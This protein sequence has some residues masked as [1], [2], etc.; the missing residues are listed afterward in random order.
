MSNPDRAFP[1]LS[2]QQK[3]K[4]SHLQR[5]AY[6]YVR[7]SSPKQVAHNKESQIYQRLL[8]QRAE[9]LGWKPERIRTI[10][11]DLAQSGQESTYRTG[12]QELVTE[13]SF[14]HVGIVFGY[15]VSRLARNN[16]DWYQLLDLAAVFDTL[17]ADNDGIY[18]PRSYNDR[19]LL[20]LKGAMS[21]AELHLLRQRL[22]GGRLGQVQ[23]GEYRQRLPTGLVR[24]QDGTV[25][26]DPDEQVR[27]VLELVFVKFE[28]L[29]SA[30][31]VV[32]YLHRENILLP[33]RQTNGL[34]ADELV[35]KPPTDAAIRE[36]LH[37]P[38]Y[39]GAFAYGRRQADPT[40]CHPGRPGTGRVA[41]SMAEWICLKQDV[42]PAY[43]TWEQY[44]ANQERLCQNRAEFLADATQ[45]Q[46]AAREGS[47]LLQGLV[48]CGICG[49]RMSAVYKYTT[50]YECSSGREY[51]EE[52]CQ[53]VRGPLVDDVVVEAFFQAL[54]PA[55]LDA[56][57]AI[58]ETQQ[59][60]RQRLVEQW[61]ER[62]RRAQYETHLAERQYQVVDPEN[63]L[64]AAE[65]ERRW[66]AKLHQLRATHEA[67]ERFQQQPAPLS[68][69]PELRQR[70]QRVSESLPWLWPKLS[71]A[72]K[73]DLLRT[74]IAKVV[75][76]RETP[77][78][79]EV[80]VV[81]ISG[82]YTVVYVQ[83]PILRQQDVTWYN[84]MVE[85]VKALWEEGLSNEQI[86][87]QL[88]AEGFHTARS[89][90]VTPMAVQKIRL[91]QG[92]QLPVAQHRK[93]L[94]LNGCLTTR[95]LAARLG[96]KRTWVY[97]RI[98]D[99]TIDSRYVTRH[100][101]TN[102]FLIQNDPDLIEQ[103]GRILPENHRA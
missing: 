31:Q 97:N 101:Q 39:A 13:V 19:L 48:V 102:F 84:E 63:R 26:K 32:R 29:G 30:Y 2:G 16:S 81:W 24:L 78:R 74:L 75:L 83:P 59:V 36:I 86:A 77:D 103:L 87:A 50:R 99:G 47:A 10:D 73:K 51:G 49:R 6:V 70:F 5:L 20:G 79:V 96:A 57:A 17:I 90:G 69:T 52:A 33:R 91:A 61:A 27:H 92:W 28:E 64:V 25:V 40:Q 95:G 41:K 80:R 42:Y 72:Q 8:A 3:V 9:A 68:L 43:I 22:E 100:P 7:Q 45:A 82:H 67:Y 34:Y 88:V 46:G 54:A 98:C 18:D 35:W 38:V 62:I 53:F 93:A 65:L 1:L 66:E 12:F 85:R 89:A 76:R 4:A 37:N 60:E 55:Q 21:E 44:L 15:E 56:L 94:E 58:L 23:R 11:T 71:N 14:G